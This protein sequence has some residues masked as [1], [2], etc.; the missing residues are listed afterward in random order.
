MKKLQIIKFF[1]PVCCLIFSA[2]M[3]FG[4]NN[5]ENYSKSQELSEADGIPVISNICPIGKIYEI[6]QHLSPI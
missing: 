3:V 4:Q 1:I 6:V 2:V 5:T